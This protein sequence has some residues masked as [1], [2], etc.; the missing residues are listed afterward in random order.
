MSVFSLCCEPGEHHAL[1]D[2]PLATVQEM[3]AN[4]F[5]LATTLLSVAA[6]R[7]NFPFGSLCF[8]YLNHCY[9]SFI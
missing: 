8:L 2:L 6:K 9:L 5:L 3:A 1:Q 7:T 4:S